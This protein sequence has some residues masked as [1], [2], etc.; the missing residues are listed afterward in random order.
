MEGEQHG[1]TI[2]GGRGGSSGRVLAKAPLRKENLSW[3]K[4]GEGSN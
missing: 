3:G 4:G 1:A 2:A